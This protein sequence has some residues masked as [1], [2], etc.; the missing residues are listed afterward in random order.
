MITIILY[1]RLN[2][3]LGFGLPHFGL[4]HL[5]ATNL[6]LWI[7]TVIK[8][9]ILEYHEAIHELDEENNVNPH[10]E[11]QHANS[12]CLSTPNEEYDYI[13]AVVRESSP[14]LFAFIIEFA[15]IG[16]TVF[17]NMWHH[18]APYTKVGPK[19]IENPHAKPNIRAVMTKTDWSHS[20]FGAGAGLVIFL[21]TT[22]ES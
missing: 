14:I 11:D 9:S 8:E 2:L 19:L 18:V 20:A 6:I 4:M 5:V 17:Y 7:K 1:P 22:T 16:A 15:L 3:D 21:F 12:S 13:F 10:A